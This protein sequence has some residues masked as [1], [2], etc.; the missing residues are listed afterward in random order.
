MARPPHLQAFQQ[1]QRTTSAPPQ[2]QQPPTGWDT[3]EDDWG[4]DDDFGCGPTTRAQKA[5]L[6]EQRNNPP[7]GNLA[8][9]TPPLPTIEEEDGES[10]EEQDD[11]GFGLFDDDNLQR[12]QQQPQQHTGT[13]NKGVKGPNPRKDRHRCPICHILLKLY[14]G[15]RICPCN[16]SDA[17]TIKNDRAEHTMDI[18]DCHTD[19][20]IR[21][22][23]YSRGITNHLDIDKPEV[24]AIATACRETGILMSPSDA[25]SSDHGNSE[26]GDDEQSMH[27]FSEPSSSPDHY[28]NIED[29][30]M[31]EVILHHI[32]TRNRRHTS[33]RD[34]YSTRRRNHCS[35][36]SRNHRMTEPRH[37][38]HHSKACNLTR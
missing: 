31:F 36:R 16:R 14:N 12:R 34:I 1:H 33:T 7:V 2:V 25:S 19:E 22:V 23:A 11:L 18:H 21:E 32:K 8:M 20:L 37:H 3:E 29:D 5:R 26:D 38:N 27:G 30:P 17:P 28:D 6:A 13:G 15:R 9:N 24:A 10:E 4:D 35:T